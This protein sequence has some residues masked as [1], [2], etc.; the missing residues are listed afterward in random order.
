MTTMTSIDELLNDLPG[1]NVI[2]ALG[3]ELSNRFITYNKQASQNRIK[4]ALLAAKVKQKHSNQSNKF[5]TGKTTPF[6]SWFQN[7][8]LDKVFG[9]TSNF[10]KYAAV[11]DLLLKHKKQLGRDVGQLPSTITAL[12]AISRMNDDEIELCLEDYYTRKNNS[13]SEKKDFDK[14]YKKPQP[15]INPHA[16]EASINKWRNDWYNPPQKPTDTRRLS[17]ITIKADNTIY[18]FNKVDGKHKGKL[19]IETLNDIH[20]KIKQAVDNIVKSHTDVL[21][22]EDFLPKIQETY[23]KRKTS[24][25][26]VASA[27]KKKTKASKK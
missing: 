22:V 23:E 8:S 17:F 10:S 15:V 24:A 12:Y 26:K 2:S 1:D 4:I 5:E 21:L 6:Y 27:P 20:E 25:E 16:T 9:S 19:S 3:D 7:N 14:K 18:E 13:I 11:G